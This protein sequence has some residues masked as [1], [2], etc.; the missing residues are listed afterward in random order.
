MLHRIRS[1]VVRLSIVGVLSTATAA[2]DVG[3][4]GS[5]SD[6]VTRPFLEA[7]GIDLVAGAGDAW[8]P[9]IRLRD[10]T[11]MWTEGQPAGGWHV[12]AIHAVLLTDGDV[13]LTGWAR[14]DPM[15]CQKGGTRAHGVSFRLDPNDLPGVGD[16]SG[17][18]AYLRPLGEDGDPS[19]DVLYCAGHNPLP[20]GRVFYT[21]GSRYE[22][23]GEATETEFGLD[24]ARVYDPKSNEFRRVLHPMRGGP[25]GQEGKRWYPTNTRLSDGRVLV[26][27]GFYRYG[28]IG[29]ANLSVE[30]FDP[31]TGLTG[32]ET[33]AGIRSGNPWLEVV[34][35]DQGLESMAPAALDYTHV[36]SLPQAISDPDTGTWPYLMIGEAGQI[37]RFRFGAAPKSG[38]Y[39]LPPGGDRLGSGSGAT[40]ALLPTG[41]ILVGGGSHEPE[42]SHRLDLYSPD[43]DSWTRLGTGIGRY[44]STAVLVPNG[45]VYLLNGGRLDGFYGDSRRPQRLD[46]VTGSVTTFS[47]WPDDP[48]E[49]GYHSFALMLQDGRFLLGGGIDGDHFTIACERTDLRIYEPDYLSRGPRPV[50]ESVSGD[51]PALPGTGSIHSWVAN[52][53]TVEVSWSGPTLQEEGGAVLM[54]TG[55]VTHAFDQNQRYIR[56]KI[57][58]AGNGTLTL[59]TPM[60]SHVAP[61]GDYNLFLVSDV[62]VP[63]VGV[64][65]RIR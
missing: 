63:S 12:A 61:P 16:R 62:G 56:L 48:T 39:E 54:A 38:A 23:L 35:H 40:G 6:P 3:A 10:T 42:V 57:V 13:L 32:G 18:T 20:D 22:N 27:G 19:S 47:P 51:T 14:R 36:Y 21:G 34:A 7:P 65:V 4:G 44:H 5:A 24:Y 45:D 41:Q 58:D 55:A 60:D 15:Q 26:T 37:H 49:R 8:G 1:D 53:E 50:I 33:D 9:L 17:Q 59:R 46:P 52:G 43:T 31:V 25:D 29:F 11:A 2:C 28:G 30:V 64:S